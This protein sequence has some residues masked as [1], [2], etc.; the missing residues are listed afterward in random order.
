MSGIAPSNDDLNSMRL[1]AVEAE[2]SLEDAVEQIDHLMRRLS[3]ANAAIRAMCGDG[4]S[5][6]RDYPEYAQAI[7]LACAPLADT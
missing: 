2:G 4:R 3:N 6:V 1:R 7:Q 5:A